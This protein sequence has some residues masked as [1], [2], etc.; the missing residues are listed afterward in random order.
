MDLICMMVISEKCFLSSYFKCRSLTL[1]NVSKPGLWQSLYNSDCPEKFIIIFRWL[2]PGMAGQVSVSGVLSDLF[3]NRNDLK[4]ECAVFTENFFLP[5]SRLWLPRMPWKQTCRDCFIQMT[6][7]L[8]M[9][10]IWMGYPKVTHRLKDKMPLLLVAIGNSSALLI[11]SNTSERRF[12]NS[13][14]GI[15]DMKQLCLQINWLWRTLVIVIIQT[16]QQSGI[17]CIEIILKS[18]IVDLWC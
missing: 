17:F 8:N 7:T 9:R 12:L 11:R 2:Y 6:V 4:Q 18:K 1:I 5:P 10:L 16:C 15:L 13:F 3:P 14:D